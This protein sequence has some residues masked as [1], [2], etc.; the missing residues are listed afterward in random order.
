M[1]RLSTLTSN[2][3]FSVERLFKIGNDSLD[4]WL[5]RGLYSWDY[6]YDLRP[7]ERRW[8]YSYLF[9][10]VGY[11]LNSDYRWVFNGQLRQGITLNWAD[12]YLLTPHLAGGLSWWEPDP[13][14]ISS[15]YVGL[16][17]SLKY[18]YYQDRYQAR[19]A[20]LE[21][22]VQYRI[23]TLLQN[24][25]PEQEDTFSGLLLSLLLLY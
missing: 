10:E 3:N 21:L 16:G 2:L 12:R 15:F 20:N 5:L 1:S 22:L 19:S 11:F 24:E 9:G 7:G 23:G 4:D 13:A 17:I 14:G 25:D 18:L 6:G 8:N